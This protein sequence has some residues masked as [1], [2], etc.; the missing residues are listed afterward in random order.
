MKFFTIIFFLFLSI[1]TKAQVDK[2]PIP[3]PEIS[4]IQ[5]P[6]GNMVVG[7]IVDLQTNRPL[8]AASVQLFAVLPNDRDS[9][10]SVMLSKVNGDFS[11]TQLP[12]FDSLKIKVT[13]IGHSHVE[14]E[15]AF[16][17]NDSIG[18]IRKDVGNIILPREAQQLEGIVITAS[19]P[20]MKMGIDKKIFD[21]DQNL[22]SKGGTAVDIMKTIPSL[23]VDVDGNVEL[24]NSAP[25][26]FVDGR[27]TILTLDQ[28]PSDNIDRIELITNPSAKYDASSGG[29]II[30][31]ILK[32]DK[33]RGFN[34]LVSITGGT[35]EIFR[36]NANLNLRQG[37]FNFFL[38]GNYN[39]SGGISESSSERQNKLDG[40]VQNYFNQNTD[41]DRNRNFKSIRGGV[42][43][44]IDNR[45]TVTVSQ[46]YVQGDFDNHEEQVQQYLDINKSLTRSGN[47][48]SENAFQFRRNNSQLNYTHKFPRSGEELNASLS[49]NYGGV[50][51]HSS[52]IN[53]FYLPDGQREDD[54]TT[55]RN[56]G[57]NNNDQWT[58][59]VDFTNPI[60]ENTKIETGLRSYI[61][62]YESVFN[63]FSVANGGESKLPLSNH[64]KYR[65]Q[66]HAA[67]FTYTGRVESFGYQ[68]GLRGEYSKFDGTLVDSAKKFGY[69]YPSAIKNIWDAL[70]PSIFLSK[71]VGERDEIQLNYSRRIRRP[72]FWQLNPFIDINDP[73]N[74][75]QGNP[76]LQ[77]EFR[78]SFEFNYSKNYGNNNNFLAVIYYRN[79]QGDITRY[80]DTL[81]ADQYEQLKN[82]GVDPDAILNTYI[83]SKS[84]NRLGLELTLQQKIADGFDITPSA[85]F[86]YRKVNADVNDLNLSNE[87][88]NWDAKLTANYKVKTEKETSVFNNLSF[89]LSGRYNSPRVIPQGKALERYS[90]DFAM[91]KDLFKDKKGSLVFSINDIL[92]TNRH[93]VIYDTPSFYQES[94]RRWSVRSFRLTFSYKFGDANFQ[95]FKKNGGNEGGDRDF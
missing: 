14:R 94:Y 3:T 81:T 66:V 52:I 1:T 76:A 25:T 79:T 7:K 60:N 67:Y 37:K 2:E 74:I 35:P 36:S 68:L 84:N 86:S 20:A 93:G 12:L 69:K 16:S 31:I 38:S 9:L 29:G 89:Q 56:S 19:K 49:V 59:K 48:V 8:E 72:G 82:S 15:F 80:S 75:Q 23:S 24:R 13:A 63:T 83:N 40:V 33:R 61:N 27:P 46:G 57:W 26:I 11:F 88:F 21:V 6:A 65:E 92:N 51:N 95:L 41:N 18:N 87:G 45:N 50:D 44:F 73:L 17:A 90:A 43:F 53:S 62:N 77:P 78:N 39:T 4:S 54:P 85:S 55:V 58:A 10:L 5:V 42:D 22:T 47:R 70:F 71:K 34:G 30:N 28:I 91:R 64:Y 32:K